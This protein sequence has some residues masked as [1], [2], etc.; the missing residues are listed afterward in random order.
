[1]WE[2]RVQDIGISTTLARIQ[3]IRGTMAGVAGGPAVPAPAGGAPAAPFAQQLAQARLLEGTGDPAGDPDASAGTTTRLMSLLTGASGAPGVAGAPGGIA[4]PGAAGLAGG[5]VAT[6]QTAG[7]SIPVLVLGGGATG[8]GG[9]AAVGAPAAPAATGYT[10]PAGAGAGTAGPTGQRIAAIATAELGQAESPPGSN[11]GPRIAEYRTATRG[12]GVGPWCAYFTSWVGR[13][14]GV[15]VGD[16]GRGHG[17]VPDVQSWGQRT[18]R[19][20][21]AGSATAPQAGD[22]VVFDRNR[23]GLTDHIG[24]VTGVRP[25][26]GITTV[27]GNSSD[28]VSARSY[29]RG[30]WTGVV[31]M[32]APGA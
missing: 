13:Q 7:G 1:V 28:R 3:Q 20:I 12:A 17:W 19:W 21:P 30:G 27:E 29:D 15:P 25:D 32:A 31:R 16:G 8:T 22:L 26:G 24:V 4:L 6:L 18:G 2:V 14:A 10:A 9:T 5:Q 11:D 23:D